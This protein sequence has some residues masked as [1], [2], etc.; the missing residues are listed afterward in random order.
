[1]TNSTDDIKQQVKDRVVAESA[2]TPAAEDAQKIDSKL[3]NQCL[4]SNS[5]GDGLL[6][7][8]LFRDQFLYVK[9]I[10]EWFKWT[11]HIWQLDKMNES[12]A[13]VEKVAEIYLEE[14]KKLSTKI[15]EMTKAGESDSEIKKLEDKQK[16]ILERVRQLR[17]DNRR[18]A[19]LKFAH[20]IDNPL[21]ITGDEFDKKPMLFPCT[22]GVIDLETGKF[23]PGRP[24]DYL[25]LGSPVEWKGIDAPRTLWEKSL[26]E[27]YN[28]DR[29]GDDQSMVQFIKRLFGYAMTGL[30]SEKIFPVFYGKTGWNGRSLIIEK[31]KH[32]MGSLAAPI[33]SEMLLSQKFSKSSS[34]PSPD[35]MILKGIRMAFASEID[36]G[37]RFSNAKIKYLTGRNE[38]TAR[39]PHDKYQSRFDPT[40]TLFVETNIEPS[41]P[42]DDK[43]F[44][45]RLLKIDHNISF[46]NRE[47]REIYERRANLNLEKELCAEDSG[48]LA[49]MVEGCLEWQ[50]DGLNPPRVVT[51]ATEKYR[52]DE[53]MLGDWIEECCDREPAAKE[54]AAD[55]FK[56][57]VEWYHDNIGKGDKLTGTWFGKQLT[58]KFDKTKSNGSNVYLGVS[59]K[60]AP[61]KNNQGD[62]ET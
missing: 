13:A 59:L 49:W 10:Q 12:L 19:C 56:S 51:E 25:S 18:T 38:I 39:N 45:E 20:T 47:P 7:A 60:N 4:Y 37:Q 57:F 41:A 17:G 43:S 22:N 8:T 31:I 6:Y 21:A 5:A 29:E 1:M 61:V 24:G 33:P 27:I 23:K 2:Q 48:I 9:N 55:L 58:K 50:R 44:W 53:D 14:Y 54:K 32:I 34:G 16:A 35:L 62:L 40:H 26:R 3:I 11:G 30:V 28:C 15:V 42:A 46:V 36:D 52:K